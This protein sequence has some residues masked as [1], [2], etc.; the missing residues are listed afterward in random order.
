[1]QEVARDEAGP[2]SHL[3]RE[4]KVAPARTIRVLQDEKMKKTASSKAIGC[5][6]TGGLQA[7]T[8]ILAYGT[9][10]SENRQK[11]DTSIRPLN[12]KAS[13]RLMSKED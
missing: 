11:D 3:L 5:I 10:N 8:L 4:G 1:V 9:A 6:T 2:Y 12:W 7:R 13:G